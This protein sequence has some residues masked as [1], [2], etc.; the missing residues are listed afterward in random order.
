V[1]RYA[2]VPDPNGP[3]L[4]KGADEEFRPPRPDP[5]NQDP[6]Y[7][8]SGLEAGCGP[9]TVGLRLVIDPN[10]A[11][12]EVGDSPLFPPPGGPCGEEFR[13]ASRLAVGAWRFSPAE[14]RRYAPGDDFDGDGT[15]DFRRA[16]EWA[17]LMVYVDV[18]FDFEILGGKGTVSRGPTRPGSRR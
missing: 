17:R 1:V 16:I 9:A 3:T 6:E 18:R 14:R 2:F 11:V 13:G 8:Q 5:Q 12:V 7:P 15:P 10:G 4:Q